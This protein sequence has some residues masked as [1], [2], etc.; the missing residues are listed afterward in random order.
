MPKAVTKEQGLSCGS[1]LLE[2][3]RILGCAAPCGV[4]A[5]P[6]DDAVAEAIGTGKLKYP[7]PTLVG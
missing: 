1:V 3:E 4:I 6:D 7:T 5:V 2:G